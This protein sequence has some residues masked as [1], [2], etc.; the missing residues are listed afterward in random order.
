MINETMK[1]LKESTLENLVNIK[2]LIDEVDY[3]DISSAKTLFSVSEG[4][5][6]I[7]V[8]LLGL[9]KR[10]NKSGYVYIGTDDYHGYKIGAT[11]NLE[12]RETSLKCGN[13]SFKIVYYKQ[14]QNIFEDEAA[15]HKT[16]SQ[17]RYSNEW[18][19]F[20]KSMRQ[21]FADIGFKRY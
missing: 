7:Y 5:L 6:S 9:K 14:S 10:E 13:P 20:P 19:S 17:F 16:Y 8:K 11:N 12:T 15:L 18:F 3:D 2:N 4:I 1:E 21:E